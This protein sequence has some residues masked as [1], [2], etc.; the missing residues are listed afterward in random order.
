MGHPDDGTGNTEAARTRS[1]ETD[2]EDLVVVVAL[3]VVVLER[4]AAEDVVLDE[5]DGRVDGEPVREND[6]ERVEGVLERG[7]ADF[8]END[9]CAKKK[10]SQQLRRGRGGG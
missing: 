2:G 1:G 8:G 10:K 4:S 6:E 5:E 7:V 9:V 3:E